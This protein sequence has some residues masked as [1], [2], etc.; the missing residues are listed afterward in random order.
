[1]VIGC[2]NFAFVDQQCR[3]GDNCLDT[4]A[5]SKGTYP[6]IE[7]LPGPRVGRGGEETCFASAFA[8]ISIRTQALLLAVI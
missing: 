3:D 1:M 4:A 8:Q 7:V 5:G 6:M 2:D